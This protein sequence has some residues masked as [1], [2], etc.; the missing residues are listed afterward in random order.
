MQP[1]KSVARVVKPLLLIIISVSLLSF[2]MR[3]GGDSFQIYLNNKLV[4]QQYVP[5]HLGVKSIQLDKST[6]ND[7]VNVYYSH[8]GQPGKSRAISIKDEHNRILSEWHFADVD[9]KNSPM[10]F[11]VADIFN[12]QKTKGTG[13]LNLFYSSQQ[14]PNG[15]LLA[16]I[17]MAGESKA[18]P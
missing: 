5:D 15:R 6:Y 8:C 1:I 18:N 13:N 16:S 14:L 17:V 10:S 9:A 11:K 7:E 4:L 2:S 12:L 3:W